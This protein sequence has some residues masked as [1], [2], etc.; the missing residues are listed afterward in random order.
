MD[1]I[2]GKV[3]LPNF[4][5]TQPGHVRQHQDTIDRF[6]ESPA[7]AVINASTEK[8]KAAPTSDT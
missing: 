3:G 1:A 8:E 2:H 6:V 7:V 4:V 5:L